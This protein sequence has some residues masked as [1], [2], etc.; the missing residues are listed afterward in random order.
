MAS[1]MCARCRQVITN[2]YEQF[3]ERLEY[4]RLDTREHRHYHTLRLLCR[5]CVDAIAVEHRNGGNVDQAELF[6]A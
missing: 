5:A 3:A 6:D 2:P 4:R 1:I